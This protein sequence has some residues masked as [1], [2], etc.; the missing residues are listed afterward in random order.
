MTTLKAKNEVESFIFPAIYERKAMEW[1]AD[2][3]VV[4]LEAPLTLKQDRKQP[5]STFQT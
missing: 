5:P 3:L 2:V 1:F 4:S